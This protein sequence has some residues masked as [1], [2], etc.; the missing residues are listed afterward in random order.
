MSVFINL[1]FN[2][3][4]RRGNE[5]GPAQGEELKL[6]PLHETKTLER[7]L[8]LEKRNRRFLSLTHRKHNGNLFL[9]R[10]ICGK[11]SSVR[12]QNP[13]LHYTLVHNLKSPYSLGKLRN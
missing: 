3:Y 13:K 9:S 4:I 5:V 6:K 1:D 12:N 7:L 10:A 2:F 11:K 8:N